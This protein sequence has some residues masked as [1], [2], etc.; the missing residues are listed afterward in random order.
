VNGAHDLGGMRGF[1]PIEI[2][3]DEPAFHHD[4]ERRAF[5]ITLASGY[6]GLW[7]LDQSRAMREQV[8]RGEYTA[9][10]Y[11]EVWLFGLERLLD[12]RGLVTREEIAAGRS[13]PSAA[14]AQASAARVLTAGDVEGVLARRRASRLDVDIQPCFAVGG[15]VMTR[16]A[17]PTGHTRLPRY[18]RGRRGVVTA[19]H[20]VWIFADAAGNDLGFVP[21]HVY[22]VRFEASE[23]WGDEAKRRDAVY[24]DLWDGH[25]EPA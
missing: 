22:T 7:N 21:Q 5:A 20:G 24:V 19:D 6:L 15:R 12:A 2:E 4:W 1:G 8:P 18:A 10:S 9:T 16:S 13:E 25:L 23:L 14:V 3:R 17:D 11:Y